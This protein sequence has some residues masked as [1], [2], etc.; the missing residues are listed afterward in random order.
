M[1]RKVLL[2]LG[3]LTAVGIGCSMCQDCLDNN[4]PVPEAPNFR[5]FY[6]TPRAGS[7]SRTAPAMQPVV[8]APG[9]TAPP[10]EAVEGAYGAPPSG[11]NFTPDLAPGEVLIE[12]PTVQQEATSTP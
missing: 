9:E 7:A 3:L 4:G 2:P 11:V 5:N 12:G 6:H 8:V 1:L 10:P